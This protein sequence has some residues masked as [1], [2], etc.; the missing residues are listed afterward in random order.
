VDESPEI[1]E[2]ST[3]IR[4]ADIVKLFVDEKEVYA[5]FHNVRD[6]VEKASKCLLSSLFR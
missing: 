4:I 5:R 6:S 1:G 3:D 2:N